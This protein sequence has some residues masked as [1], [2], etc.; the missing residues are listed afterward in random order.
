MRAGRTSNLRGGS[1]EGHHDVEVQD[2]LVALAQLELRTSGRHLAHPSST[3]AALRA[4]AIEVG[5]GTGIDERE[6]RGARGSRLRRWQRD[7]AA[8]LITR[9]CPRVIWQSQRYVISQREARVW[10]AWDRRPTTGPGPGA[11]TSTPRSLR[12]LSTEARRTVATG[13]SLVPSAGPALTSGAPPGVSGM[14]L[15]AGILSDHEPGR[16]GIPDA[17]SRVAR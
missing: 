5:L 10:P 3:K 12:P 13:T 9:A 15:C 2:P 16:V 4:G 14:P 7:S 8:K 17:R 1:V 6:S 11:Q